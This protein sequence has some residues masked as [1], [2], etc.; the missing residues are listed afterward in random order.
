[1]R[2]EMTAKELDT[3]R[4][5]VDVK[6][7]AFAVCVMSAVFQYGVTAIPLAGLFARHGAARFDVEVCRIAGSNARSVISLVVRT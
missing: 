2:G 6:I 4:A 7:T 5:P 3:L 1:M